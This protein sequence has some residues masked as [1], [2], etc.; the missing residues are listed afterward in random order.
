MASRASMM[1]RAARPVRGIAV[2]LGRLHSPTRARERAT[3]PSGLGER[4]R[5]RIH[6]GYC[7]TRLLFSKP[8]QSLVAAIRSGFWLKPSEVGRLRLETRRTSGG[9][10]GT[11]NVPCDDLMRGQ[12]RLVHNAALRK[13]TLLSLFT[14]RR[15]H[16]SS[17]SSFLTTK[18]GSS[19]EVSIA[20]STPR[21]K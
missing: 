15:T 16:S 13:A 6:D 5:E 2:G 7:R 19:C 18:T 20:L 17:S 21:L 8:A 14:R 11:S 9:H 4:E 1:I 12:P 10:L 3:C